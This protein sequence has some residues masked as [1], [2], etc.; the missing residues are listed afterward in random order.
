[1]RGIKI[2]KIT[3]IAA[4]Y[5]RFTELARALKD[6]SSTEL[7]PNHR[8]FLERIVFA[9]SNQNPLTVR[10]AISLSDL[11]SAAT[12]HKRVDKLRHLG[13]IEDEKIE[14][15]HRRKFLIPTQKTIDYFE[16]LG[17]VMATQTLTDEILSPHN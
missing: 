12:L 14:G 7:D 3:K 13:F 4:A 10:N 2:S 9:W 16:R 17:S 11:G 8:V 5:L 6:Q 15:D 1:M